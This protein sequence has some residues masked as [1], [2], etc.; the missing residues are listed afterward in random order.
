MV[1]E[2]VAVGV[3]E[4]ECVGAALVGGG[5]NDTAGLVTAGALAGVLLAPQP[6]SASP[7]TVASTVGTISAEALPA[8][9]VQR[10]RSF[11]FTQH[12]SLLHGTSSDRNPPADFQPLQWQLEAAP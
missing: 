9:R 8:P 2:G 7:A 6:A 4:A 11:R 1:V 12:P 3:V 5:V 10:R